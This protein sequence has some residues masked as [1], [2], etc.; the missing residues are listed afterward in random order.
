MIN[1]QAYIF[2]IFIF[3]GFIIGII[4]DLFR[5]LRKSFKTNDII[6]YIEDII[7]WVI[8]G[9]I[10]LYAIFKFNY[11]QIRL[12]ML[13]GIILGGMLYLLVFSNLFI[14][15]MVYL[16]NIIKKVVGI[17]FYPAIKFITWIIN[18]FKKLINMSKKKFALISKHISHLHKSKQVNISS[19]DESK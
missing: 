9:A 1:E 6:T 17:I 18:I 15:V 16:I 7:F 2:L 14:K 19:I 11:G 5:V 13:L 8:A 4:F 3:V 10:I 12:Y